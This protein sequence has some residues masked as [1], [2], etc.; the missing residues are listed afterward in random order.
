MN[1]F[2]FFGNKENK[3]VKSIIW[4]YKRK[5]K[6]DY[7][8]INYFEE[9]RLDVLFHLSRNQSEKLRELI[10]EKQLKSIDKIP[11]N[12]DYK[13]GIPLHWKILKLN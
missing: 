3:L 6:W 4:L 9:Q 1:I 8:Q 2:N 12:F 5:D 13:Y 11:E 10:D 7:E